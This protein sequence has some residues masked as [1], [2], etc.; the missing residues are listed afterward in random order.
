MKS[1]KISYKTFQKNGRRYML[2]RNSNPNN[3]YF[4]G[5][6]CENYEA[7]SESSV[8]VLCSHCT[9]KITAPP[10]ISRGYQSKGMV[11][12]WQFMKEFVHE[13]GRVFHKGVEQKNLRNTLPP[14][15]KHKSKNKLSKHEKEQLKDKLAQQ[16]IFV[17]GELSNAKLKKDQNKFKVN[18]RKIERQL[19]KLN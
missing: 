4:I 19:K 14:T 17:R 10:E 13:D 5:S 3:K 16:M 12:G 7:V 15:P 6:L 9:R 8:A 1:K 11:R 2:C 18:L